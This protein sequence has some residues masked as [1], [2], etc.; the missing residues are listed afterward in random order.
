M[1]SR[2]PRQ[3]SRAGARHLAS[4][5]AAALL[6][7]AASTGFAARQTEE[8][9]VL[10]SETPYQAVAGEID[11]REIKSVIEDLSRMGS[12]V[13][14]Y[15]GYEEAASYVERRFKELG[16]EAVETETF[17]LV[18]PMAQPDSEGRSATVSVMTGG[19]AV[20]K[21]GIEP[22]WPNLVR[23][24]K[25][26]RNGLTGRLI[27]AHKGSLREFNGQD[28]SGSIVMLDHNCGSDWYNGPLLGARAILFIEPEE[29]IRGEAEQKFMSMP[30]DLPRFW[31]P[32][33]V[34]DHLLGLLESQDRVTV[35]L[36]CDMTWE[37]RPACKNIVGRIT[38]SDPALAK[39][40]VVIQSY[41][42][43]ISV[44]P[45]L[46]PGAENACSI[47]AMFQV[48]KALKAHPPKRTIIFLATSGHFEGLAGTKWF[49]RNR[50]RGA[51]QDKR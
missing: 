6:F 22:M 18:V 34:A 1:R 12:R 48:I 32:K 42:D 3:V 47:S 40:T 44:V 45:T 43:S 51:R 38:G 19:T 14:G 26:P 49:I 35:R 4:V 50:V 9:H 23:L 10:A 24:P 36:D 13:T 7:L 31:V 21:F 41:Y 33:E 25:T 17:P 5:G 46:S 2:P 28:V 39:E 15:P 29:T 8:E 37:R 20:D 27:Y 16:L 11:A 30:V